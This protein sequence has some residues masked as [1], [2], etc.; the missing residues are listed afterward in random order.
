MVAVGVGVGVLRGVGEG[1]IGYTGVWVLDGTL[2]VDVG[3]LGLGR[4]VDVF[5]GRK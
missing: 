5:V 4:V 2:S 3:V 1:E